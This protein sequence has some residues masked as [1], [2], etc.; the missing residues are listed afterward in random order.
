MRREKQS[1]DIEQSPN[2]GELS[3]QINADSNEQYRRQDNVRIIE[4]KKE[5]DEDGYQKVADVV[6]KVGLQFSKTDI[7]ICHRV[8]SRNLKDGGRPIIVKFVRRQT[9]SERTQ[10]P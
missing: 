9:K 3:R 5:V 10:N 7:S 4:V 8:P 6:M 2:T 1:Q